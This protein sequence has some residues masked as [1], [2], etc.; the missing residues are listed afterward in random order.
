MNERKKIERQKKGKR[1]N[2]RER[3]K[4][5]RNKERKKEKCLC[6]SPVKWRQDWL[7]EYNEIERQ[8]DRTA[9]KAIK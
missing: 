8:K 2:E 9:K 3:N 6:I 7:E 1:N 5:E 4:E